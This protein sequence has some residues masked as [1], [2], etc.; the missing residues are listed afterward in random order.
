ML[1]FGYDPQLFIPQSEVVCIRYADALGVGGYVD[2]KN[3]IGNLPE[4]IDK[5]A[6]FIT[7]HT[8]VG[9]RI[10]GFKREDLPELTLDALRAIGSASGRARAYLYVEVSGH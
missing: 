8:R 4:L 6:E 5:T 2:R 9:A 7:L 1:M 3:F 10:S